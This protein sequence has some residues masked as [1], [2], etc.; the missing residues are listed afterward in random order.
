MKPI[1]VIEAGRRGG[2][3]VFAKRGS[4]WFAQIG[5]Q[6]QRILR[7]KYPG[8]AREWGKRGG[9]PKKPTLSD[10]READK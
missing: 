4:S 7:A 10:L 8:M 9:R 1:T 2:L 5:A 6:G 3:T